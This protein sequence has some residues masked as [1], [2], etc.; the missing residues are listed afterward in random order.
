MF[1][2]APAVLAALA[3]ALINLRRF[4]GARTAASQGL[5]AAICFVAAPSLF[6]LEAAGRGLL[7]FLAADF[8]AWRW[9]FAV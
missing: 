7:L 5:L 3:V 2:L 1:S 9:R 8:W 4:D 6:V